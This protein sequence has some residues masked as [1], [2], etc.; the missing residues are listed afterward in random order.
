MDLKVL[1]DEWKEA[2]MKFRYHS[3]HGNNTEADVWSKYC[4]FLVD[5]KRELLDSGENKSE[6]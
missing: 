6:I 4:N 3:E 5:K 2:M 1:E